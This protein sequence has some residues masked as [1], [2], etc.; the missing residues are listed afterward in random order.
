[1]S[2]PDTLLT[3]RLCLRRPVPDDA[4]VIFDRYAHDPEVTRY[5]GW[6]RHMSLDDTRGYLAWAAE[7][8]ARSG[9]G[10]FTIVH[11]AD[12]RLLGSTGL[13]LSAPD[14]AVTGYVLARDA[15]GAG[16]ATEALRAMIELADTRGV[17]TLRAFCHPDHVAS[18]H[19]LEKCGFGVDGGWT[20]PMVF[21]NLLPGVAQP[22][23]CYL[24]R[25]M[26]HGAEFT[27]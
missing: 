11:R 18:R 6:P 8:W 20:E 13:S 27:S 5:L 16:Y 9:V 19:V 14:G 22:V 25:P 23:V 12:G 4:G 10:P 24:R 15:W 3:A 1:M 21:P 7:E 2:A 26:P 17:V